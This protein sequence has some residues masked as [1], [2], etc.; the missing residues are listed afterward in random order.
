MAKY[1]LVG[2]LIELVTHSQADELL[3]IPIWLWQHGYLHPL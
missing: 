2:W 3:S 1:R